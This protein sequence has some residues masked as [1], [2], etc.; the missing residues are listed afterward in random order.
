MDTGKLE[1]FAVEARQELMR[2]VSEKIDYAMQEGN[3]LARLYPQ[4]VA[5]LLETVKKQGKDAVV[6]K[7]AYT[8][9]NRFCALRFMDVNGYTDSGVVTPPV[10]GTI[11]GIL[12]EARDGNFDDSLFGSGVKDRVRNI[13]SGAMREDDP[14]AAAYRTLFVA[15]CNAWSAKMPFLF[16]KLGDESEVLLPD[17]LLSSASILAKVRAAL[18]PEICS[19]VEVIGWLYQFYISEKKNKIE[20]GFKKNVKASAEN[21]PAVTQLFTP[22]WIVKYLVQNSLGRLWLKLHP[23]SLLKEQME[24][25][26]P[27]DPEHP[28]PIPSGIERPEDLRICDPCCGSAHM[29]IYAFD[30]L[31][32]IYEESGYAPADIPGLILKYNLYGLE[33]DPRAA[34]LSCFA[35][36]MKARSRYSRFLR[37]P[38][39]PNICT[40]EAVSFTPEEKKAYMDRLG[41]DLFTEPLLLTLDQ[42]EEADNFGSLIVPELE[43]ASDLEP[44]FAAKNFDGELLYWT[45]HQKVLKILKMASYLAPRYHVVVTN[46]PYLGSNNF[47]SRLKIFADQHYANAKGDLCVMF[48]DRCLEMCKSNGFISMIT[49]HSW[50]FLTSYEVFRKNL[51]DC[52]TTVAMAHLGSRAFN[53]IGGE[54]VAT[55]AFSIV[56]RSVPS[57]KGAYIRLVDEQSESGKELAL[58]KCLSNNGVIYTCSDAFKEIPGMPVAYWASENI[59]KDYRDGSAL[60]TLAEPKQG[61][62][63]TDNNRFVRFWPEVS[64][65]RIGFGVG[66]A[67]ETMTSERK[68]YPLNKGGGFRKWYGNQSYLVNY[69]NDGEEIKANVLRKYTYLKTPDFVVKNS[70]Y[71][72]KHCLSW[73]KISADRLCVRKY[74]DGFIFSDAGMAIFV[75]DVSADSLFGLLNS[76]VAQECVQI[77]A[78]TTNFESG[79]IAKIPILREVIESN[80][81]ASTV[82]QLTK[83]TKDDWDRY[84]GS[85]DYHGDPLITI[86]IGS[87]AS[88]YEQ[89]RLAW[90]QDCL[91]ARRA[92]EENNRVFIQTYGLDE[93][94][95]PNVP[96]HE[97]TLLCNPWYRYGKVAPEIE[98]LMEM[99]TDPELEARLKTDT[100]KELI[101]YAVGCMMGRYSLEKPGLVLADQGASE[102]DYYAKIGVEKSAAKFPVDDDGIIPILDNDWFADDIVTRFREFIK[103][104]FGEENFFANMAWIEEALGKDIRSYFTKDFYKDHLQRYQNRPIYWLFQSPKGAFRALVYMHRYKPDMVGGVLGYLRSLQTKVENQLGVAMQIASDESKSNSERVRANKDVVKFSKAKKELDEYEKNVLYPLSTERI[105]IDLD[106]GVKV[107]YAKF[108]SALAKVKALEAKGE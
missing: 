59:R 80:L 44:I 100:V 78:P 36:I 88:A 83:L 86:A 53:T 14:N 37:N 38:T 50:M 107:N 7:T 28:T 85:W 90:K 4:A 73:S 21:I 29:L 60:G 6:E 20:E 62:S 34:A 71:Y 1:T 103:V 43:S 3:A 48:I 27:E 11:P 19:D 42:F 23:E 16:E 25:Y 76:K 81:S 105:E 98:G 57:Y 61:I 89:L 74:P 17:D 93:T 33:L 82:R 55:T 41:R 46:P 12:A 79:H 94:Q 64:L 101:S 24:Y 15:T 99:P 84:E 32:L 22:H 58:I 5:R 9:F 69:Q 96:W 26:V 65:K 108:A 87:C 39:Q 97:I 70:S 66:C 10:G 92:E 102:A 30:L 54:I 45:T 106:D 47:N 8:W 35:L 51:I 40:L 56:K 52:N 18:T 31:Y 75:P 95:T 63:T 49:M 2:S 104:A 77:I 67:E 91:N 68:W 13:L 72:F